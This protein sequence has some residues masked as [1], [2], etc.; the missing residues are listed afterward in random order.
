MK[1]Q[2]NGWKAGLDNQPVKNKDLIC[3]VLSLIA[4]RQPLAGPSSNLANVSFVKV[5]AHAGIEGNEQADKFAKAGALMPAV[6]EREYERDTRRNE[7]RKLERERTHRLLEVD[8]AAGVVQPE[9]VLSFSVEF[10]D[11]DVLTPEELRQMELDQEF[12]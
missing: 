2:R 5:K 10:D 4:L 11:C 6:I 12:E 8:R 9:M 1:W 7:R 3:Y